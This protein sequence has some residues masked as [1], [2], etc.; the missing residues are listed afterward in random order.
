MDSKSCAYKLNDIFISRFKPVLEII[1]ANDFL[2]SKTESE[3]FEL[4]NK[5]FDL[6]V[7]HY[8]TVTKGGSVISEIHL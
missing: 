1:N 5:M 3:L 6:D 2:N 8:R 4:Y 7:H